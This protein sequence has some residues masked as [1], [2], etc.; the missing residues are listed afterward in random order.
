MFTEGSLWRENWEYFV[1]QNYPE[2]LSHLIF[3]ITLLH[4]SK[5]AFCET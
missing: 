2:A 3:K 5:F 4:E 1:R